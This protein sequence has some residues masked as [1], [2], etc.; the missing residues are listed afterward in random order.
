MRRAVLISLLVTACGGSPAPVGDA[1]VTIDALSGLPNPTWVLPAADAADV[2][3]EWGRLDPTG[4]MPYPDVLGYRALV[5]DFADG[6]RIWFADGV[7][8][9]EPDGGARLDP[10]RRL[11]QQ[12]LTT[13]RGQV[14]DGLLDDLLA[15]FP[16]GS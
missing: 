5:I 6:S 4:P 10:G 11:E 8:V 3:A 16:Q 9:R 7:A 14:A 12:V 15:G 2:V 13:G 1:V